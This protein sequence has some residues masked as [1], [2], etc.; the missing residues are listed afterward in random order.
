[1]KFYK[2]NSDKLVNVNPFEYKTN[3]DVDGASE[4]EREV[5]N[6]LRPFWCHKLVLSQFMIPGSRLRIDIVNLT[7]GVCV[8]VS[9]AGSHSFNKFFHKTELNFAKAVK[10]DFEKEEWIVKMG[11][12]YCE[13]LDEDLANL[14]P[15]LF[16]AKFGVYL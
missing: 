10:R 8:E 2:L 9:P 7:D 4:P 12:K 1:M 11:F 16:S 5:L 15:E 14:S 3:W 6:F 13:L